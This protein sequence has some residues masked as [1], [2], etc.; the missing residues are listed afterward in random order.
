MAIKLAVVD[1]KLINRQTVKDK[2]IAYKEVELMLE[3]KNGADFLEQLKHIKIL[4]DIVLMDLEMPEMNGI[5]TIKIASANH[6]QMKFI[7]LTVFED[8]D[9]I[10]DAI[11][12]GAGGYLLKDDSAVSIIDAITNVI[13][14][15][16]IPMSPSI[17]RKVMSILR[18][19]NETT[20]STQTASEN[21][22]LSDR[23]MEI[24]K[25]LTSG[26]NYKAIGEKLFISPHTVRKH[27]SNIYEKLHINSRSQVINI[28]HK[29]KWI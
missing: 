12:A 6:P 7:V 10:F 24:L 23:E 26:K 3:A 15:N 16:G 17:A 20:V 11:K 25:E 27:V 5:D 1:D 2:I 22:F 18:G 9:K 13:E 8:T 4:P 19:E 29:N 21:E 28:A 14:F